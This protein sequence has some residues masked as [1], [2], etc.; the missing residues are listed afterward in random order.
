MISRARKL[1]LGI[2][3]AAGITMYEIGRQRGFPD[4]PPPFDMNEHAAHIAPGFI[5]GAAIRYG[6]E[7]TTGVLKQYSLSISIGAVGCAGALFETGLVDHV[8]YRNTTL[9]IADAAYTTIAGT[10]GAVLARNSIGASED[11]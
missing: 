5:S 2:G 8:W 6:L 7:R 10:I 11:T 4:F 1:G 3:S 9:S